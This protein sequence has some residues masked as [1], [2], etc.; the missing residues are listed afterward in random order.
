MYYYLSVPGK[1]LSTPISSNCSS[2]Y[3]KS[4]EQSRQSVSNVSNQYQH[5]QKSSLRVSRERI[6]TAAPDDPQT[7]AKIRWK[8]DG[9]RNVATRLVVGGKLSAFCETAEI[10]LKPRSARIRKG[11]LSAPF[12]LSLF[13]FLSSSLYSLSF[14]LC[15]PLLY[16]FA[17]GDM[18]MPSSAFKLEAA[19][20][21]VLV[22]PEVPSTRIKL[23]AIRLCAQAT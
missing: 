16:V 8:T 10:P 9:K 5:K 17:R 13:F 12:S 14:S 18:Q 20:T 19:F 4:S 1:S 6:K 23:S 3:I 15:N 22:T 21:P 2:S 7:G 11:S